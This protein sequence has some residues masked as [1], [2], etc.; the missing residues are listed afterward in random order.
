MPHELSTA[1]EHPDIV[2][3]LEAMLTFNSTFIVVKFKICYSNISWGITFTHLP[4]NFCITIIIG[5]FAFEFLLF[6]KIG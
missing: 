4:S 1:L 6:F 5:I 2:A 3:T